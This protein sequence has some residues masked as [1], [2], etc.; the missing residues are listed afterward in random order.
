MFRLHKTEKKLIEATHQAAKVGKE[1]ISKEVFWMKERNQVACCLEGF[2][3]ILQNI[4]PEYLSSK[5]LKSIPNHTDITSLM[6]SLN[7]LLS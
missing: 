7:K 4:P 5:S 1:L 3:E 2:Y 6:V